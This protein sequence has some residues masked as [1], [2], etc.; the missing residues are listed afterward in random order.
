MRNIDSTLGS[1]THKRFVSSGFLIR[2]VAHRRRIFEL[3]SNLL[4]RIRVITE[5]MGSHAEK[6]SVH[7]LCLASLV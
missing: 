4:G 6:T 1:G 3:F 7:Q 5:L 2:K